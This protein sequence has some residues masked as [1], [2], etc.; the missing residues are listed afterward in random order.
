MYLTGVNFGGL[1]SQAK[2]YSQKHLNTFIT[3]KDVKQIYDWGFNLIRLP[4]DYKF[5]NENKKGYKLNPYSINRIDNFI[6]EASKFN[7]NIILE[8]HNAPGYTFE[9]NL[10]ESND[11]W[12][13]KSLNRKI[14]LEIWDYFS[15]RYKN[16]NNII[17]EVLNEPVAPKNEIWL[18]LFNEA[19][20]IIRSNDKDHYVM[21]ESNIWAITETFKEMEK[22]NDP[23]IIYSF[24]FYEPILVTH[25]FAEWVPFSGL[26]DKIVE[27]PGKPE[28]Y[29]ES[30]I[31]EVKERNRYFPYFLKDINKTWNKEAITEKIQPVL[32]FKNKYNVPVLCGEFGCIAK[33]KPSIRINWLK[34]IIEIF[35]ENDISYAYWTYKDKDFGLL[36]FSKKYKNNPNYDPVTRIDTASL[37]ILQSGI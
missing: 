10:I 33:A 32:D 37:K 14:F 24:H 5:L 26:Y 7:I 13:E 25:Q 20:K 4:V 23:N 6:T 8:F 18:K 31:D 9:P 3:L 1:F 12:D 21:T 35:R 30:I 29:D 34:D 17:Y 16:Q 19:L 36:D 11:I 22:I 15:K 2:E 27:Y 28:D